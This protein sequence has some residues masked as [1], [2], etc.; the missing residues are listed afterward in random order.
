MYAQAAVTVM[1]NNVLETLC[2]FGKATASDA[3]DIRLNGATQVESLTIL[4]VP[5]YSSALPTGTL[6]KDANN[7]LKVMP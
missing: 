3:H 7:F 4:N 6:Y 1:Q 5:T 2:Q